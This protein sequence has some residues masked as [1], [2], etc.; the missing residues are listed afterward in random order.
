MKFSEHGNFQLE[1][2]GNIIYCRVIG[3]R[4]QEASAKCLK[5]LE[6]GFRQLKGEPIVMIV[7]STCFEGGIEEAYPL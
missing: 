2:D 4:N 3:C 6:K 1:V 5:A 7:D